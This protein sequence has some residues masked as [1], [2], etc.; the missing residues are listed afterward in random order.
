MSKGSL[1]LK[2]QDSPQLS[3]SYLHTV[4]LSCSLSSDIFFCL[5][6]SSRLQFLLEHPSKGSSFLASVQANFFSSSLSV[7]VLF[8]LLLLFLE[9]MHFLFCLFIL[10]APPFSLSACQMLPVVFCSFRRSVQVSAPYNAS[11]H[12]KHFTSLFLSSLSV[13]ALFY[14]LLLFLEQMHFLFCLFILH[15][16]PFSIS[17]SQMLPVVFC[18]F[19]R[20]VQVS[21]PYN[22]SLH[23]KHFGSLFLTSFSKV[24]QKMLLFL[25]KGSFAIAILC[26]TS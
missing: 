1:S 15:A 21:A 25:L 8:Y 6:L 22:A 23:T 5:E 12:T 14:L 16:P 2:T 19:R 18:S 17:A 7:P 10:H 13:P 3:F 20:S 24:P 4:H 11:L 9:Q 26:F